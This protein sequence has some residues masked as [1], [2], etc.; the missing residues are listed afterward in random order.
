[1]KIQLD[2]MHKT[3]IAQA[4]AVLVINVGGYIGKST[5]SEI[6]WAKSLGK[7]VSFLEDISE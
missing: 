3:K 1:M 4:D 7:E 5:Y 6:E 2:E